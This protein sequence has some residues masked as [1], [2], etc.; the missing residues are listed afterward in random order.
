MCACC[1]FLYE[2]G[3]GLCLNKNLV[4]Y[5]R[6]YMWRWGLLTTAIFPFANHYTVVAKW[7]SPV[8][9]VVGLGA[10]CLSGYS[11]YLP[12]LSLWLNILFTKGLSYG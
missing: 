9:G 11:H 1:R 5:T 10:H 3:S 2:L 12:P 7:R 6:V 4:L 8:D